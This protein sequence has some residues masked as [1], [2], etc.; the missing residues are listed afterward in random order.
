[1]LKMMHFAY[2]SSSLSISSI[3]DTAITAEYSSFTLLAGADPGAL[4]QAEQVKLAELS[5]ANK[6]LMAPLS[7]DYNFKVSHVNKRKLIFTKS[8]TQHNTVCLNIT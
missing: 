5:E 2:R 6:G 3:M 8:S 4:N 1:M 7:E